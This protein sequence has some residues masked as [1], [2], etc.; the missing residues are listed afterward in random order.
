MVLKVAP[1]LVVTEQQL[2]QCVCAMSNVV[3]IMHSS[4]VFW[5][6]TLKL[7]LESSFLLVDADRALWRSSSAAQQSCG[8][9]EHRLFGG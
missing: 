5:S 1:P 2:D 9:N 7:E 6:D 3:A 4:T 8:D